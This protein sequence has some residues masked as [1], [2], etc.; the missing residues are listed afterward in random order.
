MIGQRKN[1]NNWLRQMLTA[2][3]KL[4]GDIIVETYPFIFQEGEFDIK[5]ATPKQLDAQFENLGLAGET[6]KKIYKILYECTEK[7]AGLENFISFESNK[8]P[9]SDI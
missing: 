1:L 5:T 4:M 8:T 3:K 9:N 7:Y 6:K 2:E